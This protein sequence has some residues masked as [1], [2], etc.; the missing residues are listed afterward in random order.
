MEQ[1]PDAVDWPNKSHHWGVS[2]DLE[3]SV[4][5]ADFATKLFQAVGCR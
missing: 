3:K 5:S 4:H 1:A 2:G